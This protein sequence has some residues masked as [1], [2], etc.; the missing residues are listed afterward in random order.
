M[1]FLSVDVVSLGG[2][3]DGVGEP[4]MEG[5]LRLYVPFGGMLAWG[6]GL[7]QGGFGTV[8]GSHPHLNLPPSR[9]KR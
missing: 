7:W 5:C 1:G 9:G 2:R 4:P 8:V 6:R 3:E